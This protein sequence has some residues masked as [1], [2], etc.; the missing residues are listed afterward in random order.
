MEIVNEAVEIANE[1]A[2]INGLSGK[3]ESYCGKAEEVFPE[4]IKNNKGEGP[5]SVVLDPPRKGCDFSVLDAVIKSGAERVVYISCMPS[6]LARDAGLLTG[7]LCYKDN[8]IVK[9]VN[10]SLT[11]KVEKVI[12]FDMFP[13]TK[14]VETL[15]LLC[16]K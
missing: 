6:T 9:A 15:V 2:K 7:T 13:Q 11:Y 14:H 3:A 10:P 16:R 4:I 8:K 5:L 12:P 1:T